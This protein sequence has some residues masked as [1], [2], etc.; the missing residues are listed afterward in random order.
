[1]SHHTKRIKILDF[2]DVE[3][4]S[5]GDEGDEEVQNWE[6][7]E[8][9]RNAF[10]RN[11]EDREDDWDGFVNHLAEKYDNST[12]AEAAMAST[13]H[14]P[15]FTR[16]AASPSMSSGGSRIRPDTQPLVCSQPDSHIRAKALLY[17]TK[18]VGD[19]NARQWLK[20]DE[21]QWKEHQRYGVAS[22]DAARACRLHH[23]HNR[24]CHR[25]PEDDYELLHDRDVGRYHGPVGSS[26][27]NNP[28][29]LFTSKSAGKRKRVDTRASPALFDPKRHN[30]VEK[31]RDGYPYE[32][33]EYHY[34]EPMFSIPE[35]DW[36]KKPKLFYFD[37]YRYHNQVFVGGLLLKS[38]KKRSLLPA[39]SIPA[40]LEKPFSESSNPDISQ[41]PMP[42]PQHWAF[43]EGEE[44]VY[45]PKVTR[46][47]EDPIR[48]DTPL[49]YK[50]LNVF[51]RGRDP[52]TATLETTLSSKYIEYSAPVRA[53]TKRV[54]LHDR[55]LVLTGAHRG[56]SGMVTA[57]R[58]YHVKVLAM[59]V[60]ET[61]TSIATH[62][63][64]V[65]VISSG[66]DVGEVKVPWRGALVKI[67]RG[68]FA[69]RV[70]VV[71]TVDRV[72]GKFGRRILLGLWIPAMNQTIY[73]DYNF[74][75]EKLTKMHLNSWQPLNAVQFRIYG[76]SASMSTS[77][78]P[79]IGVD[80][81]VVKGHWKGN[82]GT[83]RG[84]EVIW[85]KGVSGIDDT[86]R[87]IKRREGL[88]LQIELD[89]VR[90]QQ[91]PTAKINYLH[92]VDKKKKIPLNLAH[93]VKKGD[94]YDFQPNVSYSFKELRA[95]P[96]EHGDALVPGTPQWSP[97]RA[98]HGFAYPRVIMGI[99]MLQ[100]MGMLTRG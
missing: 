98:P 74:V 56:M 44:V 49:R 71:E 73:V 55:V 51:K 100:P 94:L 70:G 37:S 57:V 90:A 17:G 87:T 50:S 53:I 48:Y 40:H 26:L 2:L 75:V 88:V 80:V 15:P 41:F 22:G 21:S 29:P 6:L 12:R 39:L 43:E 13:S 36:L 72:E 52:Q 69:D 9:S 79:W 47:D 30:A 7:Q 4:A 10:G 3:A 78:E 16:P 54:R 96:P 62:I 34:K 82:T 91:Q 60:G 20:E 33:G 32:K 89:L 64:S 24:G 65:K 83:V 63:N 84:V 45:E 86:G 85:E 92:I 38:Y 59:R 42:Q 8:I 67:T 35:G 25:S 76:L 97:D 81:L 23:Q 77:R 5:S 93:P 95:L 31:I 1:M 58:N 46:E 61:P 11:E 18:L 14:L 66:E 99:P 28:P 27:D 68:R 19:V